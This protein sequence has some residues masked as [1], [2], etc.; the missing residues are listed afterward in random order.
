VITTDFLDTEVLLKKVKLDFSREKNYK[1][2][3][4]KI[5]YLVKNK[6]KREKIGESAREDVIGKVFVG[7]SWKI[8]Y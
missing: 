5:V 2:M 7:R 6:Q 1:M 3:S 4:E 8:L